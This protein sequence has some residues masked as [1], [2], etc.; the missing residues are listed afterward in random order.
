MK[1]FIQFITEWPL[2]DLRYFKALPDTPPDKDVLNCE[3]RYHLAGA[4]HWKTIHNKTFTHS[5]EMNDGVVVMVANDIE[6]NFFHELGH[7]VYDHSDK[8]KIKPVLD[9]IRKEYGLSGNGLK[10]VELGGYDYSYSHSGKDYE[11]DELFAISF[12][13]YEGDHSTFDNS[14]IDKEFSGILKNL[15]DQPLYNSDPYTDHDSEG[16]VG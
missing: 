16:P 3:A 12:A 15:Q 11:Y 14:E 9:K 8:D 2:S 10:W 6:E 13:F 5:R 4:L 1:T 7:F